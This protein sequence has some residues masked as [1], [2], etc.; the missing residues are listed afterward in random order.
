MRIHSG[1]ADE[2]TTVDSWVRALVTALGPDSSAA[3]F[4]TTGRQIARHTHPAT[5]PSQP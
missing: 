4:D 2:D 1:R 5:D 3:V